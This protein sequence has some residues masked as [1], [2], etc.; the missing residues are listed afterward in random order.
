MIEYRESNPAVWAGF[1]A[2]EGH[3]LVWKVVRPDGRTFGDF[4]W[5]FKGV[6]KASARAIEKDNTGPC[7]SRA[8]DGLCLAKTWAGAASGG[9]PAVTGLAIAYRKADVLGSSAD[10]LRVK[11]CHV[12]GVLDLQR[13][14]RER[15]A[16][17]ANLS[18]ANLSRADLSGANL[19]GA[20]LS[21]VSLSRA[22]LPGANLLGAKLYGA[23]LSRADLSGANLS[24]ADLSRANL[25]GADLSRA[26]LSGADLSGADLS[27]TNLFGANPSGADPGA[28]FCGGTGTAAPRG[29][30]QRSVTPAGVGFGGVLALFTPCVAFENSSLTGTGRPASR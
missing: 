17:K 21:W 13:L 6:V 22:H 1:E 18:G 11:A 5:P 7:P 29:G 15:R 20:N 9:I 2:P 8:G 30:T 25:S 19:P 3:E 12:L 14:I 26:N 4:R 28:R 10:K 24:R 16:E 23:G 27:E